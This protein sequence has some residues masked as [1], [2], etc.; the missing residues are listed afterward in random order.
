[1]K[2]ENLPNILT[3]LRLFLVPVFLLFFFLNRWEIC[4]AVFIVSGI[5]DVADGYLARKFSCITDLG[6]ILDPI[7]DKLT[8]GSVFLC[9]LAAGRIP[10]YFVLIFCTIQISQGIG[11]LFLYKNK[12]TVVKSNVFGKLAGFSMFLLCA[13]S[14]LLYSS[15]HGFF[16]VDILC[17]VTAC[18]MALA[19]ISYFLC[20]MKKPRTGQNE[21]SKP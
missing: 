14:L 6:K 16:G 5:T 9:L 8:Y 18:F 15:P 19:G 10:L 21:Q 13:L 4:A 2:K 11:A 20:Y 1:M 17:A 3:A 7:A 12:S